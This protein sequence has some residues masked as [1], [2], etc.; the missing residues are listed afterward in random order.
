MHTENVS[1][2]VG[3]LSLPIEEWVEKALRLVV[4]GVLDDIF[5]ISPISILLL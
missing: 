1:L 4:K 3:E 5:H 2:F